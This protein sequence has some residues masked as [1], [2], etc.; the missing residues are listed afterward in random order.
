[1]LKKD[2]DFKILSY[3]EPCK[4]VFSGHTYM[5]ISYDIDKKICDQLPRQT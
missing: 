3:T 5:I 2:I 4:L 1:M